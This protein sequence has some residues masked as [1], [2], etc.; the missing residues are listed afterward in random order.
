MFILYKILIMNFLKKYIKWSENMKRTLN[1]C[2]L[3]GKMYI[4][5][6]K[7]K[8]YDGKCEGYC[9]VDRDEPIEQCRECKLNVG[10]KE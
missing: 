9:G 3:I 1:N 7:P 6:G 10:Y 8:Q 5:Q 4:Y 2:S